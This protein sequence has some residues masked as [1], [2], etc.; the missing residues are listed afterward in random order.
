[1]NENNGMLMDIETHVQRLLNSF[2]KWTGGELIARSGNPADDAKRLFDAPFIVVSHGT[3]SDPILN[4]GNRAALKLWSLDW[5]QLTRMPSRL[6]AEPMHQ[7]ERAQF[8]AQVA[9]EGFVRGYRGV[10]IASTGRRFYIEDATIWNVLDES[11]SVCGQAATFS[12]WQDLEAR[13]S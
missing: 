7:A 9:R 5:E 2:S 11:G 1:V 4:Y 3:Q 13:G 6:T 8:M 12:K 10:R